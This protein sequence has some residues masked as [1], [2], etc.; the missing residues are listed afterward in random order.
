MFP[1]QADIE[2]ILA[3]IEKEEKQRLQT[4]ESVID[5][6]T[7]RINFTFVPHPDK[8]ELILFGGEFF[9]G[10]KVSLYQ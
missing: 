7:R 9:N 3:E 4:S 1:M 6:P 2:T 10:Q 8:D 5:F